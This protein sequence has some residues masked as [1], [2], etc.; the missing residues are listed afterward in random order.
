MR[1]SF[2]SDCNFTKTTSRSANHLPT[3]PEGIAETL[4]AAWRRAIFRAFGD[5]SDIHSFG[6]RVIRTRVL[7]T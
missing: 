7:K 3:P 4:K 2:S 1:P 5:G 6:K